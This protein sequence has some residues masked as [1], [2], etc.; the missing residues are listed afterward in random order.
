MIID[1]TMN[2]FNDVVPFPGFE[3]PEIKDVTTVSK[4]GWNVRRVSTNTHFATHIDAPY[5]M[6]P[7]GKRLEEYVMS[8]RLQRHTFQQV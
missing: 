6:L 2:L 8:K 1:L 7:D 4:E 5:H 3:P